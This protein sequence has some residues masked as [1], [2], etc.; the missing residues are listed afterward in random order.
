MDPLLLV[1]STLA[2]AFHLPYFV[3]SSTCI[4]ETACCPVNDCWHSYS[5]K[6]TTRAQGVFVA[7]EGLQEFLAAKVNREYVLV[8]NSVDV[9]RYLSNQAPSLSLGTPLKIGYAGAIYWAQLDSLR[10]LVDAIRDRPD[11]ELDLFGPYDQLT[12]IGSDCI[13][14]IYIPVFYPESSFR[15]N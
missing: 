8:P 11:F 12:Y 14:R 1:A 2:V 3:L 13:A 9:T 5:R 10:R 15:Q 7:G 6:N 4:G